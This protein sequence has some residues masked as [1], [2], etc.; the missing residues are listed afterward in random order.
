MGIRSR[1][2]K[3]VKSLL[4]PDSAPEVRPEPPRAPPAPQAAPPPTAPPKAVSPQAAPPPAA[5]PKAVVPPGAVSR[6][7]SAAVTSVGPPPSPTDEEEARK[8]EKQRRFMERARKG[9]LQHVAEAGG[10]LPMKDMHDFSERR[11]FIAHRAFSD[12]MEF[13]VDGGF[14]EVDGATMDVRLTDAGRAFLDG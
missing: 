8:L 9:V 7:R 4:K 14:V 6:G 11:F 12:M 1:L 10:A 13:F 3:R 2:K 5:P